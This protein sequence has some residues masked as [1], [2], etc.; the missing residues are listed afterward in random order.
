MAH[1]AI[2][3]VTVLAALAVAFGLG[4]G[5]LHAQPAAT[6]DELSPALAPAPE[7]ETLEEKLDRLYLELAAAGDEKTA[8]PIAEEIRRLWTRSGSDSADFLLERGRKA[9]TEKN[10]E[11]ARMH[12]SALTRL[13]PDFAEGWNAAATLAYIQEDFG[14]A[15]AEIERALALEPRHFSALV[16]LAMILERV[17]RKRAALAAW[18]EVERIYPA[19][20]RVR[21][22][23]ERLAPEVDGRSL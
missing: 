22:A 5:A 2:R 3:P 9:L 1:V 20:P 10:Y 17:E 14:R 6:P 21:D 12:L 15:V 18:R 13:K 11:R 23:V 7:V 16:G 8:E 4:A 19:L